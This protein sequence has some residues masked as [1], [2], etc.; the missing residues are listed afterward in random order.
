MWLDNHLVPPADPNDRADGVA[1][2]LWAVHGGGFYHNQK[3]MTGPKT[4]PLPH[5]LHWFKWEA[6]T[7]WLSGVLLFT[8]IYWAGASTYLIDPNVMPLSVP[9]AI[10]ISAG[11]LVVGWFVYD[12]LCRVLRAQPLPLAASVF[13]FVVAADWIF[14]HLLAR[15]RPFS[16]WAR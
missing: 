10:A 9:L 2:E 3:Y 14:F 4:Q 11:S 8:I 15:V 1:G 13:A 16:K 12:A 5:E 7:T 6:Y